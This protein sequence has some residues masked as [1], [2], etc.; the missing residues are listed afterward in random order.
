MIKVNGYTSGIVDGGVIIIEK[1]VQQEFVTSEAELN[2]VTTASSTLG[3]DWPAWKAFTNDSGNCW[4]AGATDSWWKVEFPEAV[5][6]QFISYAN[7]DANRFHP[8]DKIYVSDDDSTYTEITPVSSSAGNVELPSG[9][10]AKYWRFEF[11]GYS[12][13]YTYPLLAHLKLQ[14]YEQIN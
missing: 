3:G 6:I 5:N 2:C 12:D 10:N 9:I 11:Y 7:L 13:F 8:I 14:G 4:V 1:K